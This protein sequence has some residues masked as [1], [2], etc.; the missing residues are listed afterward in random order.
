MYSKS[1][2]LHPVAVPEGGLAG[3]LRHVVCVSVG[4]PWMFPEVLSRSRGQRPT[5][6]FCICNML[7]LCMQSYATRTVVGCCSVL[8]ESGYEKGKTV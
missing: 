5:R 6:L 1:G 4:T 8:L 2:D 3:V 7:L